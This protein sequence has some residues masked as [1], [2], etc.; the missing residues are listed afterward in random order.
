MRGLAS[1]ANVRR[2]IILAPAAATPDIQC[3]LVCLEGLL[4][5]QFVQRGLNE[6]TRLQKFLVGLLPGTRV[7]YAF[8][9]G[10]QSERPTR[11]GYQ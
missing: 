7:K 3:R 2:L 4:R 6:I 5:S 11:R 9:W 10:A 1:T 8:H